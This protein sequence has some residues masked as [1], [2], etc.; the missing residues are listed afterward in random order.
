MVIMKSMI[1]IMLSRHRGWGGYVGQVRCGRGWG[2]TAAVGTC[3]NC[4]YCNNRSLELWHY[5]IEGR[6]LQLGPAIRKLVSCGN[7]ELWNLTTLNLWILCCLVQTYQEECVIA[8]F[9]LFFLPTPFFCLSD[10]F[11]F[12]CLLLFTWR[13]CRRKVA[14]S[15]EVATAPIMPITTVTLLHPMVVIFPKLP[16]VRKMPICSLASHWYALRP[17]GSWAHP[18]SMQTSN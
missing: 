16:V 1:M 6:Q 8:C 12:L 17:E 3:K 13:D 7:M 2:K 11:L 14:P 4:N 5:W 15:I 9:F 10:V 18:L